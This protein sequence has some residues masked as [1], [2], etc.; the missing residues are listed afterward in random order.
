MNQ[1]VAD[2]AELCIFHELISLRFKFSALIV[3]AGLWMG[4]TVE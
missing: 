1:I 3:S 4:K 2:Y